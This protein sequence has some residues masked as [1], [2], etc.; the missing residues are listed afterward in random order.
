MIHIANYAISATY[1]VARACPDATYCAAV[2]SPGC[3][4]LSA[5][6]CASSLI[7][8]CTTSEVPDTLAEECVAVA[9]A[10]ASTVCLSDMCAQCTDTQEETIWGHVFGATAMLRLWLHRAFSS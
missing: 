8:V 7:D 9:D 4:E 6:L 3:I 2:Q 1:P 10:Q 5:A